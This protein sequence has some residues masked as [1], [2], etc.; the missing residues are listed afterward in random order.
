MTKP[1]RKYNHCTFAIPRYYFLL[2]KTEKQSTTH[3]DWN[4]GSGWFKSIQKVRRDD[5][6]VPD[7]VKYYEQNLY[8][9]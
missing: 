1:N 4:H 8:S 9:C 3:I 7:G 2:F 5:I 6:F